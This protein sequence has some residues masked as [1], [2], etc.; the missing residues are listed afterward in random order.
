[1][2]DFLN[3][4]EAFLSADTTDKDP[5]SMEPEIPAFKSPPDKSEDSESKNKDEIESKVPL[6]ELSVVPSV[7]VKPIV[8]PIK[9]RTSPP[10]PPP[11]PMIP[12]KPVKGKVYPPTYPPADRPGRNT[13][14][15]LFIKRNI[16]GP[17]WNHRYSRLC[18]VTIW[19][20]SIVTNVFLNPFLLLSHILGGKIN[21]WQIILIW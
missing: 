12:I 5:T 9:L 11:I 19:T 6:A 7:S 20:F 8:P 18:I 16:M 1:M 15:L 2:A 17:L 10:P 21:Y 4:F 14:Q 3:A 13:N